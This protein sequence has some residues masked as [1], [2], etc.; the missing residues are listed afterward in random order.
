MSELLRLMSV[1]ED[2]GLRA[3]GGSMGLAGG[4][5]ASCLWQDVRILHF[6]IG[7]GL[8][9]VELFSE[10]PASSRTEC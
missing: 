5:V 7:S 3:E 6:H 2:S 8:H 10:S 1:A 4:T 9:C